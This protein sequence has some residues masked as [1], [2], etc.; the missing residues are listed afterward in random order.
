MKSVQVFHCALFLGA[1]SVF[2]QQQSPL[3]RTSS[4][5]SGR[6]LNAIGEKPLKA[7]ILLS[8]RDARRGTAY[9]A[10]TD[11]NGNFVIDDLEP[12]VYVP[13]LTR[14]GFTGDLRPVPLPVHAGQDVTG[15]IFHMTP[16]GVITGHL[17]EEDGDPMR[18]A[19][20]ELMADAYVEG[21]K[22][23]TPVSE[24][25]T[26][27]RGDFRL[28][29][30][31]PGTFYVRAH[32]NATFQTQIPAG[33]VTR[34]KPDAG[35]ALT[36]YPSALDP[37][38][39]TPIVLA[40]GAH[41][42]GIDIQMRRARLYVVRGKDSFDK[43]QPLLA[44]LVPLVGDQNYA[45]RSPLIK[46]SGTFD[47]HDVLPGSYVIVAI[48][49]DGENRFFARERVEVVD[50]DVDGIN[51]SFAPGAEI[52]GVVRIDGTLPAGSGISVVLISDG[53]SPYG[54]PGAF[55]LLDGGF[56]V[57]DVAPGIYHIK[58][59]PSEGSYLKSMR[60]G[61][62]QINDTRLD[63]TKG[64][65]S[66]LVL[67]LGTDVGQIE[68]KVLTANGDPAMRAQVTCVPIGKHA[69]R[70]DF[71]RFAVTDE[72]G[73]F[74]MPSV[75]P[76]EYKLFAWADAPMGAPEDPDFRKQFEKQGVPLKMPPNSHERVELTAISTSLLR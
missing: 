49:L 36:Y 16:A 4:K 9:W 3:P 1:F 19:T 34:T 44:Q 74:R 2:A 63:L 62:E 51:L 43:I 27:S 31:R 65:P 7:S 26:N 38:R 64:A 6:V 55:G 41:L 73:L 50:A 54:T 71:S 52:R 29:G 42:K 67:T 76:G 75:P 5:V 13:M 28:F 33:F 39:A 68:G 46:T 61:D 18:G 15:V 58:I 21:K 30:L 10:E 45:H 56:T 66:T 37:A 72:S 40:A 57:K 8:P 24:T 32:S 47:F 59:Q 14:S 69:A 22:Q 70:T 53:P 20:V 48:R 17:F 35:Q 11:S 25:Q 60:V 23:L 12:G